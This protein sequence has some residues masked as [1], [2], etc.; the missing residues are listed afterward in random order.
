MRTASAA[1]AKKVEE[2]PAAPEARPLTAF[3]LYL[4]EH[5]IGFR[6]A[7]ARLGKTGSYVGM[8]ARGDGSPQLVLAARIQVFTRG[9]VPWT[10]WLPEDVRAELA[11]LP[12]AR[13]RS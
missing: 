9:A 8:L 4:E 10:A 7:A 5:G 13:R 1:A 6:E 11:A 3:G 2:V 12:P